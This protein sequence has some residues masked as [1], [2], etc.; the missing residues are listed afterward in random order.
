MQHT[1][2]ELR[3]LINRRD[4]LKASRSADDGRRCL[5]ATAQLEEA[6]ATLSDKQSW[7]KFRHTM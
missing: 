1:K 3:K 7:P 4:R 5:L 6:L 2:C